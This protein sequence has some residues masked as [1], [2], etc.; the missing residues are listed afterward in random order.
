MPVIVALWYF[1]VKMV[2]KVKGTQSHKKSHLLKIL[3]QDNVKARKRPQAYGPC[4][5]FPYMCLLL[6]YGHWTAALEQGNCFFPHI[7]NLKLLPARCSVRTMWTLIKLFLSI[8][9][10]VSLAFKLFLL[11]FHFQAPHGSSYWCLT[12][13]W[14]AENVL[15][16]S[17]HLVF[18]SLFS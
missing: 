8:S 3:L 14:F 13:F 9:E 1:T 10:N 16:F 4:S 7:F 17:V 2:K 11:P 18:H 12:A 6:A 15:S 5:S